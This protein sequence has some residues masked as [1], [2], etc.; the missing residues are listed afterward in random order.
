MNIKQ[1]FIGGRNKAI[2]LDDL[3]KSFV[4]VFNETEKIYHWE[5]V[6][7]SLEDYQNSLSEKKD[8]ESN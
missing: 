5:K 8:I 1:I 2:A 4:L 6:W 3:N 7:N